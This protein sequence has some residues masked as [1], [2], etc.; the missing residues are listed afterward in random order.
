VWLHWYVLAALGV[1]GLFSI[2]IAEGFS[3]RFFSNLALV[4]LFILSNFVF[5][6]LAKAHRSVA[7]FRGI[8]L[9]LIAFDLSLITLAMY[10]NGGLE[11]QIFILYVIPI[12]M[13]AIVLQGRW[14]ALT[15]VVTVVIISGFLWADYAGWISSLDKLTTL[16]RDYQ[17]V[18]NTIV[19]IGLVILLITYLA[20]YIINQLQ[21]KERQAVSNLEALVQAQSIAKLGS[22]EWDITTDTISWSEQLYKMFGFQPGAVIA[23]EAYLERLHPD[24]REHQAKSIA[25]SL[26]TGRPYQTVHRVVTGNKTRIIRSEGR[27]VKDATGKPVKLIGTAQDITAEHELERAKSDFVSIASHQLRTPATEVKML[28]ALIK[29]GYA[30][31]LSPE[32]QEMIE[33]AHQTNERQIK[34]ANDL[35]GIARL[36]AS[37][38][39]LNKK[40]LELGQ[41]LSAIAQNIR[42]VLEEKS[43]QLIF[44]PLKKTVTIKAD[45]E[46]LQLAIENLIDNASKYTP[47]GGTVTLSYTASA[48]Q[49]VISIRD[50][51]VGIAKRDQKN[52]FDIYTR[53]NNQLSTQVGGSGLGLYLVKKLVDL[54]HGKVAVSSRPK[55]GSTFRIY[56]PR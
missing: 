48:A 47:E 45:A 53:I 20:S 9:A 44:K 26:K 42:P 35:L 7:F 2:Y 49:A 30:G 18:L 34:V 17:Y 46:R 37:R 15:A 52:M 28:L 29:D 21:Q 4:S 5:Y 22:W 43:Q 1:S 41:L 16:G 50:T 38:I 55:I 56:L 27:V 3:A 32:Q 11:S 10:L 40:S 23:Y 12:L 8:A 13:S 39:K 31:A 51:G 24:D 36:N 6:F 25:R 54:H 33:T 19:F 14:V